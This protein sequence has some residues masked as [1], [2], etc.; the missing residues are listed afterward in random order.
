[1]SNQDF[2]DRVLEYFAR[3]EEQRR[4]DNQRLEEQRREDNQRI[5]KRLDLMTAQIAENTKSVGSLASDVGW[6]K[7]KMEAKREGGTALWS[8][9]AVGMAICSAIIALIAL[10]F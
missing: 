8:K 4:E 10:F 6:I 2:Q 5:E 9:I 1:M 7:G 3:L